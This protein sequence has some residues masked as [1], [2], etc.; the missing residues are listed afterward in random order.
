MRTMSSLVLV[1]AGVFLAAGPTH[2]HHDFIAQ[3]NPDKP[4]TLKGTLTKVEWLNPHGWIYLDV[5]SANG[6]LE[7]WAVETGTTYRL[8]KGGLRSTDFKFG[9]EIVVEGFAARDGSRKLAGRTLTFAGRDG[10]FPLGR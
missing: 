7:P 3:F 9:M 6:Q 2:A 4:L 5:K 10:S 1:L 8:T